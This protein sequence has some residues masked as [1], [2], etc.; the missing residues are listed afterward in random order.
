L[1]SEAE[2]EVLRKATD[3]NW[4]NRFESNLDMVDALRDALREGGQTKPSFVSSRTSEKASVAET[5]TQ[6]IPEKNLDGDP[7]ATLDLPTTDRSADKADQ[8]DQADKADKADQASDQSLT[9]T[10]PFVQAEKPTEP[11][12]LQETMP[13]LDQNAGTESVTDAVKRSPKAM[14]IVGAGA[15]AILLLGYFAVFGSGTPEPEPKGN[16][17]PPVKDTVANTSDPDPVDEPPPPVVDSDKLFAEAVAVMDSNAARAIELFKQA[18]AADPALMNPEPI[19]LGGHKLS[20][21]KLMQNK[22]GSQLISVADDHEPFLWDLGSAKSTAVKLAG[23]TNIIDCSAVSPDGMRLVTGSTDGT[24]RLWNLGAADQAS[25]VLQSDTVKHNGYLTSV[26]WHPTEPVVITATDENQIGIWKLGR[27]DAD[28]PA[29]SVEETSVFQLDHS[30]NSLAMD[31]AGNWLAV[32]PTD[33]DDPFDVR[34]YQWKEIESTFSVKGSPEPILLGATTA[35][36]IAFAR[37]EGGESRLV[38]ADTGGQCSIYQLAAEPSL[39][40]RTTKAHSATID[41]MDVLQM[42]SGDVIATG[43][44]DG[45]VHCWRRTTSMDTRTPLDLTGGS[46]PISC[47]DVSND[48]RW[49]AAGTGASVWLWDTEVAK[50]GGLIDFSVG[51]SV[52]TVAIDRAAKWLIAGCDDGVIRLWDLKTAKL[53]AWSFPAQTDSAIIVPLKTIDS[54]PLSFYV[55]KN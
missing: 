25:L 53:L 51:T 5:P 21:L 50:A 47:I 1:V 17:T 39:E 37:P 6:D 43:S 35:K 40:Q 24:A 11:G 3:L 52:E 30:I 16:D 2:Q 29:G 12:F 54:T 15:S 36:R 27:A 19:S 8:A 45:S 55:P 34:V 20:V 10:Q 23:H 38:V 32:L 31:P 14:A 46:Q 22:D 26:A 18:A 41:V 48:G 4:E 7:T 9:E 28:N 42:D 33:L 13:A 49:I 44:V